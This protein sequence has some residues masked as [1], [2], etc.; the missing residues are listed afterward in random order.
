MREILVVQTGQCGNQIG[1]EF[2]RT[3]LG[4]HSTCGKDYSDSMSTF[5][6]NVDARGRDLGLYSPINKLKAR[7]VLIDM[8]EG[9]LNSLLTS[10]INSIFDETLLVKD[11]VGTGAGNNFGAGYAGYGEEHGQRALDII[12]HALENCDSP[13]GFL[14]FSSLGGGTGS[15]LGSRLL[16]LTADTF[17]GLSIL[18]APIIPSR[19]ANDV[20]TSPYN[21]VFSLSSLLQS[22]DVILPFDNESIMRCVENLGN[23][24]VNPDK[25]VRANA[26]RLANDPLVGQGDAGNKHRPFKDVNQTVTTALSCITASMRFG[27]EL[28]VDLNELS[29]NLVPFPE[30]NLVCTS[31]APLPMA[32]PYR[33]LEAAVREL[34]NNNNQL[35][36]E[37][38][39]GPIGAHNF[40][41]ASAILGRSANADSGRLASAVEALIQKENVKHPSWGS[42]GF[43]VGLCNNR[44]PHAECDAVCLR[45]TP[46]IL[47]SITH[48]KQAFNKM[49]KTR[50]FLHHYT[51]YM[52]PE[53]I[54]ERSRIVDVV[55]NGYEDLAKTMGE[56]HVVDFDIQ[57]VIY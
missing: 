56:R 48:L 33:T 32:P 46:Q 31:L 57:P 6:R 7:A 2:W 17:R 29:V 34:L 42:Q 22:A 45:N 27:G 44:P 14:F 55:I 40:S 15:G 52:S 19:N 39:A 10:D 16:E 1:A 38:S 36:M 4:E 53:D 5:F 50:T 51:N 49:Y 11:R 54:E 30:L 3:I 43:K 18:S 21:S 13:Q 47:G 20:I 28:N 35:L 25:T 9:V 24:R 37:Y 8:E 23:K 41:L 12:Q 26:K